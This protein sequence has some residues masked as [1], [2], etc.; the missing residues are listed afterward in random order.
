MDPNLETNMRAFYERAL[1]M[2]EEHGRFILNVIST[3]SYTIGNTRKGLPE[4]I[5]VGPFNPRQ[6]QAVLNDLSEK[7]IERGRAFDEGELVS[8]GGKYPVAVYRASEAIKPEVTCQAGQILGRE[9]YDVMQV[10]Y[11]DPNGHFPGHKDC[12]PPYNVKVWRHLNG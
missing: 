2:I 5:I 10:V 12:E 11:C 3:H 1:K 4:L 9:D 7:M 6:S 8:L